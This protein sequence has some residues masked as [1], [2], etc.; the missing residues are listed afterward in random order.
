MFIKRKNWLSYRLEVRHGTLKHSIWCFEMETFVGYLNLTFVTGNRCKVVFFLF[1]TIIYKVPFRNMGT[2]KHH[3]KLEYELN[4]YLK[5]TNND[6]RPKLAC[7]L[8]GILFQ[9]KIIH[10]T[11]P[12]LQETVYRN[13]SFFYLIYMYPALPTSIMILR[14]VSPPNLV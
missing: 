2:M 7:L 6:K 5:Q 4:E 11:M 9:I 3:Q 8:G 13:D 10:S 1:L 14:Y 12:T